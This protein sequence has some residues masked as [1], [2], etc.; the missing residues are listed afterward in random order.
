MSISK[1]T[2][3]PTTALGWSPWAL[4]RGAYN[5]SLCSSSTHAWTGAVTVQRR[6]STSGK[7]TGLGSTALLVDKFTASVQQS[8]LEVEDGVYYRV[9]LTTTATNHLR[10]RLSQ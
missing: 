2:Y 6:F 1:T 4:I 7:S 8:G 3:G 9:G 5:F 10:I